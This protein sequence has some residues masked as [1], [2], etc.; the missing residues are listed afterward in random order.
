MSARPLKT[1]LEDERREA[2]A[3]ATAANTTSVVIS[4]AA[5]I[6]RH[7]SEAKQAKQDVEREMLAAVRARRGEYS[8]E[9][10]SDLK[11]QNSSLIYMMLF[12]TKARQAKALLS[13]V[14]LGSGNDKPWTMRPTP[15]PSLPDDLTAQLLAEASEIVYQAQEMGVPMSN[16]D[17]RDLLRD[18]KQS[19][20]EI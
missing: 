16:E 18:A 4:L 17:I 1:L 5:Q 15:K 19:F 3:R 11:S 10:L 13:D 12:A 14:L 6:R 2:L 20:K 7:W 9:K 8:P